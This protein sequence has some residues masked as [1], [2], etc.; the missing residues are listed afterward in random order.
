M[1][2]L[3]IVM[4]V[5]IY[6]ADGTSIGMTDYK[7]GITVLHFH[8]QFYLMWHTDICECYVLKTNVGVAVDVCNGD[9]GRA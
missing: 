2:H 9:E 1:M 8:L 4:V 7:S 5:V 3:K 6:T